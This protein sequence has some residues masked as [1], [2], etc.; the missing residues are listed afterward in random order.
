MPNSLPPLPDEISA[1]S[2]EEEAQAKRSDQASTQSVFGGGLPPTLQA[3]QQIEEGLKQLATLLPS[4]VPFAAQTISQLR[5]MISSQPP[6]EA[7]AAAPMG[8]GPTGPA[9]TG[10]TQ[11]P[12]AFPA[13]PQGM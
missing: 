13:P 7:A 8:L 1:S 12:T 9:I 4:A 11:N 2:E 3:A 5:M 6:A 10:M